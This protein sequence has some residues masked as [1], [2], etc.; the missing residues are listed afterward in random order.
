MEALYKIINWY[1]GH[2]RFP[3]KGW[4]YFYSFLRSFK[5]DHKTYR[6]KLSHGLYINL[7]PADHIQKEIFWYGY[8]EKEAVKLWFELIKLDSVVVD[9]GSN[10]GYYS[11]LAASKAT[12]GHIYAFEPVSFLQEAIKK[13]IS[14]NHL[15]NISVYP[16]AV[17]AQKKEAVV[18]VSAED[19]LGMSGLHPPE[20]FSGKTENVSTISLDEWKQSNAIKKIDFIKIDVEGSEMNVLLGMQSILLKDKPVVF[21][22]IIQKNLSQ[23]GISIEDVYTFINSFNYKT[24]IITSKGIIEF[25]ERDIEGYSILLTPQEFELP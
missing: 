21:I 14:L 17:S 25:K 3:H 9:V 10:I 18:Y 5:L 13:N 24:N 19:N 2:F 6:K 16:F 12:T 22:E 15:S 1:V 7:V 4:K 11:L 20:N 23:F 8:Y